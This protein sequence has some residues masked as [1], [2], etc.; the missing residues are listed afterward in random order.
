MD[1]NEEKEEINKN[2]ELLKKWEYNLIF[3][4]MVLLVMATVLDLGI[5]FDKIL[6]IMS[7]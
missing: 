2:N 7:H 6:K 5:P 3:S 1:N 4:L